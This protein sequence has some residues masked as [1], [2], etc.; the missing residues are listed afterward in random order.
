MNQGRFLIYT[1]N[2]FGCDNDLFPW[3]M[4]LIPFSIRGF[5]WSPKEVWEP[6][7]RRKEDLITSRK[8]N[9]LHLLNVWFIIAV[10]FYSHCFLKFH[11]ERL[12]WPLCGI[13]CWYPFLLSSVHLKHWLMEISANIGPTSWNGMLSWK[14]IS[15]Y[16]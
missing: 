4:V 3:N 14:T 12:C 15:L 10:P 7:L 5:G 2:S 8:C 6:T 13:F 16:I 11:N 9:Y 1:N